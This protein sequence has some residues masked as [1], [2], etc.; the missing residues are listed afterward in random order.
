MIL[1]IADG[2]RI[3]GRAERP[4]A[5]LLVSGGGVAN[6]GI[7]ALQLAWEPFSSKGGFDLRKIHGA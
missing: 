4:E 7:R 6:A 3:G 2:R 5:V 1:S